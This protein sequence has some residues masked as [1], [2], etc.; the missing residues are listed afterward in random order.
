[1]IPQ[2]LFLVALEG[3]D[4]RKMGNSPGSIYFKDLWLT[5]FEVK[6]YCS[7]GMKWFMLEAIN[8]ID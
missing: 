3:K 2:E 4:Y 5:A 1:M 8:V 6:V 7:L